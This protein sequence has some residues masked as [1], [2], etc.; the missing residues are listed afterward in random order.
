MKTKKEIFK[1][2]LASA[3]TNCVLKIHLKNVP[4]P[5]I[6]AVERVNQNQIVLKSTCLYGY[7]LPRRKIKLLE[8]ESVKRYKTHFDNP[9]F[10]KLRFIRSNFSEIRKNFEGYQPELT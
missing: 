3:Q 6:T 4:N 2:I 9:I 7:R 1:D 8:I 10:Q 5:M